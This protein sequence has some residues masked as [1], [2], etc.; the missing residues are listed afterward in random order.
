MVEFHYLALDID[1][2]SPSLVESEGRRQAGVTADAT[3]LIYSSSG[4]SDDNR[5]VARADPAA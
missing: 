4:A 2:G 5:K 3:A 1:E